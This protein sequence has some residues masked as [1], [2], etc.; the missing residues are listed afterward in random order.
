[1]FKI[2]SAKV[3][4][5]F[6]R[7]ASDE[8]VARPSGLKKIYE[9]TKSANHLFCQNIQNCGRNIRFCILKNRNY[10]STRFYFKIFWDI[11]TK[12]QT[13]PKFQKFVQRFSPI[14]RVKTITKNQCKIPMYTLWVIAVSTV[15]I[16]F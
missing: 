8:S 14:S 10:G 11:S 5:K 13:K 7:V 15:Y 2:A 6:I 12:F 1:M 3:F 4:F 9:R 16:I